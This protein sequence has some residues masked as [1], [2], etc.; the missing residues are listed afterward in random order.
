MCRKSHP[1]PAMRMSA[2]RD[3]STEPR[4]ACAPGSRRSDC[5]RPAS[6]SAAGRA[7]SRAA[8]PAMRT[9]VRLR[10]TRRR[11]SDARAPWTRPHSA[12][13]RTPRSA[14]C[15][16]PRRSP[17][18]ATCAAICVSPDEE[19]VT[20]AS[21]F[22]PVHAHGQSRLERGRGCRNDALRSDADG[23]VVKQRLCE[24]LLHLI[25]GRAT[26]SARASANDCHP[27]AH[28][29]AFERGTHL[30][31]VRLDQVGAQQAHAAVDVE[32]DAT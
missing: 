3:C 10:G 18:A 12:C 5:P 23:D 17:R 30:R 27:A 1:P 8:T 25:S 9:R 29:R 2:L 20:D 26:E 22:A 4:A 15:P 11:S 19:R 7:S 13:G 6:P 24:L 31:D 14:P 21:A 28:A 16:P 32:A